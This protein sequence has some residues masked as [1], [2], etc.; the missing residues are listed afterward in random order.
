MS[1]LTSSI[2]HLALGLAVGLTLAW[3]HS[4]ASRRAAAR[5]LAR[6]SP[7]RLLLGFPIRVAIPAA[8]MFALALVSVWAL[9]SGLLAF[10]VGQR[11]ALAR[12]ADQ[13]APR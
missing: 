9:A 6:Q 11:L 4:L 10:I 5:A 7:A 13:P 2:L 1:A 12:L 3:A 8:A